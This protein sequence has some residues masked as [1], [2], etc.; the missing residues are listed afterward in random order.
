MLVPLA[1][2][3]NFV[4]HRSRRTAPVNCGE[5]ICE[6]FRAGA[7]APVLVLPSHAFNLGF[8]G[9]GEPFTPLVLARPGSP[10]FT[11]GPHQV[12]PELPIEGTLRHWHEVA[13]HRCRGVRAVFRLGKQVNEHLLG[14]RIEVHDGVDVPTCVAH[15][16]ATTEK[17]HGHR[18]LA[19]L[20]HG[21]PSRCRRG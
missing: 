21:A 4:E 20:G 5:R 17:V 8:E 11:S 9:N 3:G 16:G 18:T 6:I 12:V 13:R 19:Q 1:G 2:H 14:G 15:A 10:P 7:R